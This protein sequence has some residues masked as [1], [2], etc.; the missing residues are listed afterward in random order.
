MQQ[1][2]EHGCGSKGDERMSICVTTGYYLAY[3]SYQDI[4]GFTM[5]QVFTC[6]SYNL[7]TVSRD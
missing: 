3:T 5:S 4:S 7:V 2:A 6:S 1:T